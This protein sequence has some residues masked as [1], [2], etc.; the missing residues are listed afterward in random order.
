MASIQL[1]WT[2]FEE[3]RRHLEAIYQAHALDAD[4]GIV[5][6]TIIDSEWNNNG[7]KITIDLD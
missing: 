1:T 7:V 4:E 6:N 5:K 2:Q 3:I